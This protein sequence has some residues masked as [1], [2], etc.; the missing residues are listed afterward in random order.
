MLLGLVASAKSANK[1]YRSQEPASLDLPSLADGYFIFIFGCYTSHPLLS[2]SNVFLSSSGSRSVS[3]SSPSR[4]NIIKSN[5]LCIV[6]TF[7]IETSFAMNFN[8]ILLG[9]IVMKK[10]RGI[11]KTERK[12]AG[13][14]FAR[15]IPPSTQIELVNFDHFYSATR[16]HKFVGKCFTLYLRASYRGYL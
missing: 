3:A 8:W 5:K 4:F 10:W 15:F 12:R 6:E 13:M 16:Q 9:R 2:V 7:W 1:H 11:C 14:C